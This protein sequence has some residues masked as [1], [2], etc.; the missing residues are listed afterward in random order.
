[1]PY[2]YASRDALKVRLGET[3]TA[4]D[5]IYQAILEAVSKQVDAHCKRVF[6]PYLATRYFTPTNGGYLFL[7]ADLL[8][9]T[10]LKTDENDDRIY[11]VIWAAADYDLLPL[12]AQADQRPYWKIATTPLGAE[13]F[14][15][16]AK[17]V[18]LAGKWGYWQD[19]F[20]TPSSLTAGVNASTTTMP[21]TAGTDFE[22]LQT[23][24]VDS[25][26]MYVTAIVGN[27]L[28]V[29]RAQNGTTAATHDS[30]KAVKKH[31][32]PPP[33][34]EATL[35]QTARVFRRKDTP[36]GVVGGSDLSFARNIPLL[37]PDVRML[38]ASYSLE[39]VPIG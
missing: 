9:I 21:V 31:R 37:D 26:Q 18:E 2:S 23:I 8:A 16:S 36:F 28:T 30:G 7:D 6:Q 5:A 32:Y 3:L 38:L 33:V 39:G 13:S 1:M 12:N 35:I 11:E 15:I 10:T 22:A 29:E 20:T 25:E 27:N 14:P 4:N 17:S 34:V 24:E 19:L